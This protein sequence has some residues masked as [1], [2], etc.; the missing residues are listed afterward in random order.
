MKKK[1]KAKQERKEKK[2]RK[3]V[4][5]IWKKFIKEEFFSW[6]Q[7]LEVKREDWL[8][9]PDDDMEKWKEYVEGRKISS[10]RAWLGNGPQRAGQIPE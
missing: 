4:E 2:E 6:G 7:N 5:K 9:E 1:E 10:G 8:E 3:A